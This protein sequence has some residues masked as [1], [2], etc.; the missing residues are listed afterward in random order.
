M[1]GIPGF[2][3]VLR[4]F[5]ALSSRVYTP[6]GGYFLSGWR[7]VGPGPGWEEEVAER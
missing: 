5:K 7:N 2:I 4:G 1:A 6:Q 3:G